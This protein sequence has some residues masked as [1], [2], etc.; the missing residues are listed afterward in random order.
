MR[1]RRRNIRNK[2]RETALSVAEKL[3]KACSKTPKGERE[4]QIVMGLSCRAWCGPLVWFTI[5][6]V[7][8]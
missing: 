5:A 1:V 6:S 4:F 8:A 7:L 2:E 3:Q